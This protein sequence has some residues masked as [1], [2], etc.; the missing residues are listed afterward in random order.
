MDILIVGFR[1][2]ESVAIVGVSVF[3]SAIVIN[4]AFEK[5]VEVV[6]KLVKKGC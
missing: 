2:L 3:V 4:R 6:V 1:I 5:V